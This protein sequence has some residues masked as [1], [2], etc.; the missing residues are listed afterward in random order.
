[1]SAF[2]LQIILAIIVTMMVATGAYKSERDI[3]FFNADMSHRKPRPRN[4]FFD[5]SFIDKMM[6]QQTLPVRTIRDQTINQQAF[7][8]LPSKDHITHP[9]E[10]SI[11]RHQPFKQNS[12]T[13]TSF[14]DKPLFRDAILKNQELRREREVLRDNS[15]IGQSLTSEERQAPIYKSQIPFKEQ[16]FTIEKPLKNLH[17]RQLPSSEQILSQKQPV[18]V[19]FPSVSNSIKFNQDKSYNKL[20]DLYGRHKDMQTLSN[21]AGF[22]MYT[23]YGKFMYVTHTHIYNFNIRIF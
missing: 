6:E 18:F 10:F 16:L 11:F 13:I 15:F 9:P 2:F 5:Q 8:D 1:M 12:F 7:H 23:K 20:I 21:K 17:Y 3:S 19:E 22:S 14:K 4:F